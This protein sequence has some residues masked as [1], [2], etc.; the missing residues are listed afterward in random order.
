MNKF[1]Q[2]LLNRDIFIS[3]I[4][5][6]LSKP[7][8]KLVDWI[9]IKQLNWKCLSSNPHAI[10]LLKKY[11][12]MINWNTLH[13]NINGFEILKDYTHMV[14]WQH[15]RP[16]I[17]WSNYYG[18][19]ELYTKSICENDKSFSH[20]FSQYNSILNTLPVLNINRIKLLYYYYS[21]NYSFIIDTTI[22]TKCLCT[23]YEYRKSIKNEYSKLFDN[24]PF[25][26][27]LETQIEL[28]NNNVEYHNLFIFELFKAN[29]EFY[30][31]YYINKNATD[32]SYNE[33]IYIV[34]QMLSHPKTKWFTIS[35]NPCIFEIDNEETYNKSIQFIL[36]IYA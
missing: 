21:M 5:P 12:H 3:Y 6:F 4:H 17:S 23:S 28:F 16:A 31:K 34:K 2:L 14:D 25:L 24:L 30:Q 10:D 7:T 8:Y 1:H 15:I 19:L 9:D 36:D 11:S 26:Y 32:Y 29:D 35:E 22:H 18:Q 13:Y 20:L 27:Q 33:L